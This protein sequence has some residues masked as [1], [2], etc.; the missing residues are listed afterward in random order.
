VYPS[1]LFKVVYYNWCCGVGEIL[2][3]LVE[4]FAKLSAIFCLLPELFP[5]PPTKLFDKLHILCSPIFTILS[6]FW[7]YQFCPNFEYCGKFSE[8]LNLY[9]QLCPQNFPWNIDKIF[10]AATL[11]TT[12][13]T[14]IGRLPVIFNILTDSRA[15]H[16][17]FYV[18]RVITLTTTCITNVITVTVIPITLG[19]IG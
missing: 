6:K 1:L 17:Q 16:F 11:T 19:N 4:V 3:F 5:C 7:N 9:G 2:K 12:I 8:R 14:V 15:V 18:F 13:G 10:C